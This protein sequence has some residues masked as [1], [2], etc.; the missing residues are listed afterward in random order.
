MRANRLRVKNLWYQ[1]EANPP[2]SEVLFSAPGTRHCMLR[3]DRERMT[4]QGDGGVG[5]G[6][7]A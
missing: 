7:V 5:G 2:K 4:F 3:E 1:G 6:G